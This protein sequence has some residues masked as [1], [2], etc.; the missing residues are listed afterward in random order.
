MSGLPGPPNM[1]SFLQI[2]LALLEAAPE[3][4]EKHQYSLPVWNVQTLHPA[5]DAY[6]LGQDFSEVCIVVKVACFST[7]NTLKSKHRP[8]A[9]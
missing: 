3:H 2:S 1:C 8:F 5:F 6:H 7:I 4:R 9:Q